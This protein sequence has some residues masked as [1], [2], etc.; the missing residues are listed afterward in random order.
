M[1]V[2]LGVLAL[3]ALVAGPSAGRAGSPP[4]LTAVTLNLWHD[5]HDWP[6][7]LPV[8]LSALREAEP[9][10]ILLQEVLQH[11]GLPNQARTLADSLGFHMEFFTVDPADGPK[12]Y[13]NAVLTRR[14]VTARFE[15]KLAPLDDWRVA[16]LVRV[17]VDGRPLDIAVTHL[18]HTPEGWAIRAEQTADLLDFLAEVR[19]DGP[20]LLGGD[21]NAQADAP[22]LAPL[23]GT[24]TDAFGTL[25]PGAE[26]VTTLNTAYGHQPERIDHLLTSAELTPVASGLLLDRPVGGVWGSDHFGVW[27][28]WRW[29]PTAAAP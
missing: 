6:A 25:H 8:I 11:D 17:D 5:Q 12:R 9:D 13:G 18:H 15:R 14:P 24:L 16:G 22:E 27:A 23:F 10:V 1:L 21:F 3:I 4:P 26:N 19:G 29:N 7:R 28:R 2:R 20:L